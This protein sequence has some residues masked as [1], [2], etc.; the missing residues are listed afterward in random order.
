[1]QVFAIFIFF[2]LNT[3]IETHNARQQWA[4]I[5]VHTC[6]PTRLVCQAFQLIVRKIPCFS[7]CYNVLKQVNF[8]KI[9]QLQVCPWDTC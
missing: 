9:T 3:K 2:I 4:T 8:I 5:Q 6:K 1:M 7:N